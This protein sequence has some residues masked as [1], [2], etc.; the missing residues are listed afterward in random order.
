MNVNKI[1]SSFDNE[2]N[3]NVKK[4]L[5]TSSF[6]VFQCIKY[7]NNHILNFEDLKSTL[8]SVINQID[9]DYIGLL[10]VEKQKYIMY[11]KG[12]KYLT[13]INL[14]N[15][16]QYSKFQKSVD[17]SFIKACNISL[18]FFEMEEMYEKCSILNT[19]FLEAKMVLKINL[20]IQN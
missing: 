20:E 5:N 11:T 8:V 4:A 10:N 14:L 16:N 18:N 6:D 13:N 9:P 15:K 1:F 7:F 12:L 2:N 17:N 3:K 19:Y